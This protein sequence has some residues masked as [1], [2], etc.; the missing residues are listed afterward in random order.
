MDELLRI[1]QRFERT[2]LQHYLGEKVYSLLVE[3][4]PD[5]T[6]SL[7]KKQLAQMVLSVYG[8]KIF[9]QKEFRKDLMLALNKE[10]LLQ[11]KA[12][13][14]VSEQEEDLVELAETIASKPWK[15][16]P[17]SLKIC[18]ICGISETIFNKSSVDTAFVSSE[19]GPDEVF[20]EL[21][22]YQYTIM[23]RVLNILDAG[24]PNP[25]MLVHMPTGTGKTK[26]TMHTLVHYLNFSLHK[27]GLVIWIAHT[28][29]LIIQ[30]QNTFS[31]VWSHLGHGSIDIFNLYGN[32]PIDASQELNG[33]AFCSLQKLLKIRNDN[34]AYFERI[35]KACRLVVFDEAHRAAA[36]NTR[37]MME[38][39]LRMP[40][41]YE[42]RGLIGLTA[43]PGRVTELSYDNN[44]LSYM[45]D[46][47]IIEIDNDV[48]NRMNYGRLVALNT[49]VQNNVI[50]Y[51]QE[52][53]ILSKMK[54]ERLNYQKSFSDK[55]LEALR[56][57]LTLQN[58]VKDYS[59]KQLEVLA[60][61]IDRNKAI[62]IKLSSLAENEVPTIVFACSV[63]HA[64]MI[65]AM[66][67]INGIPNSLVLGEQNDSDRSAAIEAFKK[68]Q[69]PIIINFDV[70]T[71]G[72]DST[73]IRCVMIT[74]PTKSIVLYSQMLGRGLRGPLMGGNE[75]CLLVDID[76]NI[77]SFD[78]ETAFSHFNDYWNI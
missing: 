50:R 29:E 25:R 12:V 7:T 77:N 2:A 32:R 39:L 62:M 45:F 34:P 22:D 33:I 57:S 28:R 51:F 70:L 67:S 31:N 21:L 11:L 76:D 27:Q 69:T 68:N 65:S 43:T 47:R 20:Y 17:L 40:S 63:D 10:Q 60:Q 66:L 55:D 48:L 58:G 6:G 64:K 36:T 41:G 72:F 23:H 19:S 56:S 42:N 35:K 4:S 71:T 15:S 37:E 5:G 52:R 14:P 73:N 1:M 26:T 74:R 24:N 8:V 46:N 59:K 61:N 54:I 13:L 49:P 44:V 78:N 16:S 9:E 18:S 53:H 30:A 75:E 38:D 3:W